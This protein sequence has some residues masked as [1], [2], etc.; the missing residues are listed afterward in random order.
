MDRLSAVSGAATAPTAASG[1]T[2]QSGLGKQDFLQLLIAQLKNQDPLQPMD[3]K[4]FITQMA[5]FNSLEQMQAMN[6]T[7]SSMSLT[8]ASNL[9]GKD[10]QAATT[11]GSFAGTVSGVSLIGGNVMVDIGN[12]TVPLAAI[13]TVSAPADP[14]PLAAKAAPGAAKA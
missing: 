9:I 7:M 13:S 2:A 4:E 12:A 14:A 10:V 11:S 1:K 3:D 5:Q 6:Q 8:Q